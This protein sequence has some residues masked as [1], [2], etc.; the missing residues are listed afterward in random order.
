MQTF[1]MLTR[2]EAGAATSPKTLE[3]LERKAMDAIRANCPKVE[4]QASYA[5]LG[6]YDYVDI[7]KAPDIE[8]ATR[9]SALIRTFGHAR[10]EI[11][12]ATEWDRFKQVVRDLPAAANS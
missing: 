4:W 3:E 9:V 8:T 2:L 1:L 5:V 10:T 6:P 11:W 12:G 7:F